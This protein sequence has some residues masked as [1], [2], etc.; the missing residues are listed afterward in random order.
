MAVKKLL[1]AA[2]A[3]V[4]LVLGVVAGV[5]HGMEQGLAAVTLAGGTPDGNTPW[6]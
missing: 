1:V 3:V 4:G 5:Q 6:T 2:A